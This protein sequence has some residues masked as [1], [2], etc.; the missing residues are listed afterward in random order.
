MEPKISIIIPVYNTEKYLR[1]CLDSVVGQTL[2]DIEIICVNDGSTDN[3]LQI[4]QEYAQKDN[5]IKVV[6]QRSGEPSA[7]RNVGL[8][9]ATADY[10]TFM[11]SDDWIAPETYQTALEELKED[12]DIVVFG[13]NVI[14]EGIDENSKMFMEATRHQIMPC[15]GEVELNDTIIRKTSV[16]P[17]NKIFKKSI[18]DQNNI[19]FAE[20]LA[21][22]DDLFFIEYALM[23][24]K[25]Y[26][27]EKKLYNYVQRPNSIMD[28]MFKKES[29]KIID[30]ILMS[31]EL[32]KFLKNKNILDEHLNLLIKIFEWYVFSDYTFC[33]DENKAKV[34]ETAQ[35][36]AR[37]MDLGEVGNEH[38]LIKNLKLGVNVLRYLHFKFGRGI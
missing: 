27:I 17:W 19:T 22:E 38:V 35:E 5:R 10:I 3:S 1:K 16:T 28:K 6:T 30:G 26:Y 7:T 37:K 24:K 36:I 13:A 4:L 2:K 21:H 23:C 31:F 32:Y 9:I 12:I 15:L 34:M 29:P 20:G 14:S 8:R 33:K 11:D 18:L 25:A